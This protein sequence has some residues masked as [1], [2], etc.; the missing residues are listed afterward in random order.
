MAGSSGAIAGRRTRPNSIRN[1]GE[2]M[3]ILAVALALAVPDN[4]SKV[5]L[6]KR[7]PLLP[8]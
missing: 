6:R 4:A 8:R 3:A 5:E 7:H 2:R 1:R